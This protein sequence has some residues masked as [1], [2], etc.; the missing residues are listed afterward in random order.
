MIQSIV[1]IALVVDDYD[2]AIAFYTKKLHFTLVEDTY[3]PEQDK[4][5]VVVSPPGSVGTTILLAKAS[6]PEQE[7][8]VGN[9]AGGRVFLFL[10]TDDFWRDYNDMVERG[11]EFVRK[12]AEQDYGTVAVFKDLY[13]N[14]WDL[15][16]LNEDHPIAKRMK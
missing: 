15:L 4:R 5:W 10:N 9:Q 16:Q 3:Q 1:H 11:V 7:P 13:G 6:K 8:F 2:E 14:L 12:P